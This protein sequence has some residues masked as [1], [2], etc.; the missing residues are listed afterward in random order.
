MAAWKALL[1]QPNSAI[2]VHV[3]RILGRQAAIPDSTVPSCQN[4]Q[5]THLAAH[6]VTCSTSDL[7]S[8]CVEW[9]VQGKP[10]ICYPFFCEVTFHTTFLDMYQGRFSFA[11]SSMITYI[12]PLAA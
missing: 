6:K 10:E 1:S 12:M 2:N 11:S 5:T 7:A 4:P 9:R 3:R 8:L